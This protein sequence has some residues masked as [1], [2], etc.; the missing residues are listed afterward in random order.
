MK[1][2]LYIDACIKRDTHSRTE[3]LGRAY[4]EKLLA[5]DKYKLNTIVLENTPITPLNEEL[6][7]K[8]EAYISSNDFSDPCFDL[9][10]AFASADEIIIAAPYWDLSFPSIVK[11]YIEQIC[12]RN[13]TFH[14]N[15]KGIPCGMTNVKALTYITTAGGYI[16]NNNFGFDYIK[17]LFSTLFG[18]KEFRFYSAEG[19]DI[20]GNNPE[21]ILAEAIQAISK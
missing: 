17:G 21:N 11:A 16:G 6:L 2:L 4:I 10:K 5:S 15:E 19:L 9:A 3:R 18:I 1:T 8:R 13:L 20:Y 14:Y 12:V 7:D